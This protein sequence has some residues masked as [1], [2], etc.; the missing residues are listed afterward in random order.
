MQQQE[1]NRAVI[2]C[3]LRAGRTVK[4]IVEFNKIKKSTVYSVKKLYDE[5]IAAGGS[6]DEFDVPRKIHKRRSD[7]KGPVLVEDIRSI[8]GADPGRSMRSIATEMG[9][10]ER[11]VRR[12]MQEDI[13]YK[14]YAMRRGQFMSAAMKIRRE[15]KA[16][17]LLA[18]IKHP[19]VPNQLI[20]F[21]DEKNFTQDQKVNR[22][23][24]RWL[25]SDP[26]D[27]QWW[28]AIME[29]LSVKAMR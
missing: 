19:T 9:V 1:R 6:P 26:T 24:N 5:F 15:D 10:A 25:C 12:I 16:K 29:N 11:T 4:E 28:A 21:S 3:G 22:R 13:R 14:S 7:A 2:A 27:V 8:V 20:F 23:N 18:K 17:K